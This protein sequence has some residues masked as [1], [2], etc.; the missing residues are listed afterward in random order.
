[1]LGSTT[2]A[3]IHTTLVTIDL[4]DPRLLQLKVPSQGTLRI[5]SQGTLSSPSAP[6]T[7][8]PHTS[9]QP[10]VIASKMVSG[11]VLMRSRTEGLRFP[12]GSAC[13]LGGRAVSSGDLIQICE[14]RLSHLHEEGV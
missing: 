5:P 10:V 6:L 9:P 7:P 14:S 13:L 8:T 12:P 11:G 4:E 1:M 2:Q 3:I